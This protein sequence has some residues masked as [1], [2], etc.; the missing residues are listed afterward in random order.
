MRSMRC[1]RNAWSSSA[2]V[3]PKSKLTA[4]AGRG[5]DSVKQTSQFF[6]EA[7]LLGLN[8]LAELS[9]ELFDQL[10]RAVAQS[11]R[12]LDRDF[13]QL[14]AAS[15]AHPHRKALAAYAQHGSRLRCWRHSHPELARQAGHVDFAAQ[16][17]LSE[18]D[19]HFAHHVFADPAKE[20]M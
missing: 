2:S 8:V 20:G 6:Q 11:C 18:A 3:W 10:A 16:R 12:H 14:I 5:S 19:R 17:R 1:A 9:A 7:V 15:G 4:R 13:D